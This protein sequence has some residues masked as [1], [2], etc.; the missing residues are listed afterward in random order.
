MKHRKTQPAGQATLVL[1]KPDAIQRGLSG[2]VLSRLE[3]LQLELIGA[4]AVHVSKALAE[5]H[6]QPIRDKPFFDETVAH[7]QG[8]LHGVPSVLAL[9]FWGARAIERV[10]RLAGATHPERADPTTIRGALG[11]MTSAGLMENVLHASSDPREAEREIRLWFKPKELLREP[12]PA[13][14][15]SRA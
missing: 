8:R 5:E 3:E 1:I 14:R 10:R 15:A 12:W 2:A 13:K 9:V 4:K 6:Y 7:L 11:R